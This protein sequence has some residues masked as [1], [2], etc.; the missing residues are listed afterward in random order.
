MTTFD[1]GPIHRSAHPAH[2]QALGD[3]GEGH[4]YVFAD[5][6]TDE[7]ATSPIVFAVQVALATGRPLLVRGAPGSGKSSL[8][9]AVADHLRWAYLE[10]VIDAQMRA[11][12]LL[13]E[14]D[15]VERL[16]DAQARV[17]RPVADYVR[18]GALWRAFDPKGA[19]AQW[20]V[21]EADDQPGAVLLIDE[22]DKAEPDLP[23]G[24]LVA[25]GAQRFGVE[26]AKR[27]VTSERPTL[28][29]VTTNAQRDLSRAFLRRCVVLDLEPPDA[30]RL[31]AIARGHFPETEGITPQQRRASILLFSALAMDV[32]ARRKQPQPPSVAEY[33]DAIRAC[34]KLGIAPPVEGEEADPRWT[35]LLRYLFA[36]EVGG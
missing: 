18:P 34:R 26:P 33:L 30:R 8:A 4:V 16:S 28:V 9:R 22:I 11:R 36:K 35:S 32:V 20:S 23:D 31:I 10:V 3:E 1:P 5:D 29:I 7:A 24:L 14:V 21:G 6:R 27:E 19:T 17:V 15:L 12:D 13:W 2:K 25:L